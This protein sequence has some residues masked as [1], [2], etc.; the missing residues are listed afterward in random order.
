MKKIQTDTY[1]KVS[2]EDYCKARRMWELH[3]ELCD[4]LFLILTVEEVATV[5]KRVLKTKELKK[6]ITHLQKVCNCPKDKKKNAC[7]LCVN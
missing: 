7:N 1:K 6:F 5:F 2:Y 4:N 3:E